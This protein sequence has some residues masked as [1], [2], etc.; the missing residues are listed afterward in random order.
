[1]ALAMR[2]I[3]QDSGSWSSC[4]GTLSTRRGARHRQGVLAPSSPRIAWRASL[5]RPE[6]PIFGTHTGAVDGPS[7]D[8]PESTTNKDHTSATEKHEVERAR[9][10]LAARAPLLTPALPATLRAPHL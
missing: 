7:E 6:R 2:K 9:P 4:G 10:Q 3:R 5:D 1:M 8:G